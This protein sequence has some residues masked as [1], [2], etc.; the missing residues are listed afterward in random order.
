MGTATETRAGNAVKVFS[1]QPSIDSKAPAGYVFTAADVEACAS[2][3]A[4]V[5]TGVSPTF[6]SVET[7]DG[8]V[9]A[10]VAGRKKPALPSGLIPANRC[11]RG[12]VT[13]KVPEGRA[14]RFVV[15]DSSTVVKWRIP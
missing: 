9:W 11:V 14:A 2:A 8:A 7:N 6:F 5:G 13:F 1:Y 15:F 4:P 3:A 12:W 10:S